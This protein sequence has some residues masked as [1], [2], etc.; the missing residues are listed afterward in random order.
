[1]TSDRAAR[2]AFIGVSNQTELLPRWRKVTNLTSERA[3]SQVW[4]RH[5]VDCAQLIGY[6]PLARRWVDL[7]SGA[8][9]PGMVITILLAKMRGGAEVHCIESDQSKCAFLREVARAIDAP[10]HVH[11]ART[12]M[13][14]PCALS[15]VDAIASRVLAPCPVSL[16]LP[17]YGL[18]STR[19][20]FFRGDDGPQQKPFRSRLNSNIQELPK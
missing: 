6:A 16:N 14:N 11:A 9:F 7:G 12:E 3:F 19:S 10:A 13:F 18:C 8:G 20:E 1:V 15:L 4:T 2:L 17:M 5:L